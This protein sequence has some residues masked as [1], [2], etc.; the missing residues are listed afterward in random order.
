MARKPVPQVAELHSGRN[1]T[2]PARECGLRLLCVEEAQE[3][4]VLG[5]EGFDL[6]DARAGPILHPGLAEVVL[7]PMKAAIAHGRKYRHAPRTAPWAERLIRA[8]P[9]SHGLGR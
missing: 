3:R 9:E 5:E 1:L 2:L 8:L 4:C 7:D 6:G